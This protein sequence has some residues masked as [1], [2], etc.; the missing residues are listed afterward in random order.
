MVCNCWLQH[1]TTIILNFAS[2]RYQVQF[3]LPVCCKRKRIFYFF[4]SS[5]FSL[6]PTFACFAFSILYTLPW[7]FGMIL[8]CTIEHWGFCIYIGTDLPLK[9]EKKKKEYQCCCRNITILVNRCPSFCSQYFSGS[10]ALLY[11]CPSLLE[12]QV[13][14]ENIMRLA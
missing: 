5:I 6:L 2:L 12:T 4:L 13:F 7:S 9:K 10:C 3:S 11:T 1:A 8:L 14:E